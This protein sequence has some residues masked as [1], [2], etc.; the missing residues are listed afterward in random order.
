M[1]GAGTPRAD[2]PG[3]APAGPP[4]PPDLASRLARITV[5]VRDD[6][7]ITRHVDRGVPTYVVTDPVTFQSHA[8]SIEDYEIL[9][10]IRPETSL[11]DHFA[12]LVARGH[13]ASSEETEFYR[14]IVRLHGLGLLSLPISNADAILE[15]AERQRRQARRQLGMG[16][17][18][19]RVPLWNPDRF[20]ERTAFTGRLLF[21]R[22]MAAV[23][24]VVV[25]AAVVVLIRRWSE[26]P[27]AIES[28]F[29]IKSLATM[30]I[31]LVALKVV[32]EFGH[33]WACRRFG[34]AVPEMGACFILFTPCAYVDASAAW[35]FSRRWPRIL[36]SLAGMYFELFVAAIAALVWAAAE[37]GFVRD[38]AFQVVLLASVTTIGFNINPL[39]RFDGY[40][41]LSDA[42][43][44]PNL[45]SRAFAAI[46]GIGRRWLLGLP[47]DERRDT[48]ASLGT[49]A[50]LMVYGVGVSMYRV[51]LVVAISTLLALRFGW[52]GLVMAMVYVASAVVW[53]LGRLLRWLWTSVE[54]APVRFRAVVGSLA[55]FAL[56][57]AG[58]TGLPVPRT[59]H[60]TGVVAAE[61]SIVLRAPAD[62]VVGPAAVAPGDHVASG[63]PLLV[64]GAPDLDRAVVR[65]RTEA[66]ESGV[67]A[68]AAR[69]G[70]SPGEF[71][72]RWRQSEFDRS[73]ADD[74]ERRAGERAITAP[75]AG[76]VV[77][78]SGWRDVGQGLRA[79]DPL[80]SLAAG[81]PEI[82]FVLTASELLAVDLHPGSPVRCRVSAE[83]ESV[84]AAVVRSVT[85]I[86]TGDGIVDADTPATDAPD[87]AG[88]GRGGGSAGGMERY[89]V[90]ARLT[91]VAPGD[92]R[93]MRR[94]GSSADIRLEAA[95]E[96]PARLV[97]RRFLAFIGRL[98]TA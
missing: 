37:P 90:R 51:V 47:D 13:L 43:H 41:V 25:A 69:A 67:R 35:T 54:T 11:G 16:F 22:P 21:S 12:A 97:K 29:S 49:R 5:G 79:G 3:A 73:S 78:V 26:V 64:V 87:V 42:L 92:E 46:G 77:S 14:F 48:S 34:G 98:M 1:S 28:A 95:R 89:L 84:R 83:P 61:E 4:A 58:F 38:V 7:E 15:R 23:W 91:G 62:G 70:G 53:K 85:R 10:G 60:A 80:V 20:L 94:L 56:V 44:M 68:L 76:V 9:V 32:H 30:W 33:A 19:L 93:W 82:E 31:M 18:F 75:V 45:Q 74:A 6:L 65:G 63:A 17:L 81:A 24:A 52:I 59:I 86:P 2:A 57:A 71:A 55:I 36:V 27:A 39:M 96:T 40:Y 66:M 8:F 50:T 72:W 88:D